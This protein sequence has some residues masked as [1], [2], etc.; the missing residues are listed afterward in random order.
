MDRR[1]TIEDDISVLGFSRMHYV[2]STNTS[3]DGN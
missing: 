2:E 3:R 1:S